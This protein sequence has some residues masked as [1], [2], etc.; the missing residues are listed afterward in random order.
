MGH[1]ST[2]AKTNCTGQWPQVKQARQGSST[3]ILET[4]VVQSWWQCKTEEKESGSEGT[5]AI[6]NNDTERVIKALQRLAE[7]K[8]ATTGCSSYAEG[9]ARSVRTVDQGPR[10]E[11]TYERRLFQ[12]TC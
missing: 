12:M 1:E 2:G 3:P 9:E 7:A 5:K 10:Y 4:S 8:Q 6:T 11:H